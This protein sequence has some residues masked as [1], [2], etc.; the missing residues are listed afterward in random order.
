MNCQ[1]VEKQDILE[2]YL[3]GRLPDQDRDN[4]EQHYFEC[5]SCFAS[6]QIGIAAWEDLKK[7]P[8]VRRPVRRASFRQPW[9]WTPAFA[10]LLIVL[11]GIWWYAARIESRTVK[12]GT[13]SPPISQDSSQRNVTAAPG[14]EE[15][16][17][18]EPPPYTPIVVRGSEDS[19]H[20]GF[21]QAMQFYSKGDYA[22]AIPGLRSAARASP[23]VPSFS[24]YLGACYLLTG[25]V[26]PAIQFFRKTVSIAVPAYSEPSHFYLAKAYLKKRDVS[27][28]KEELRMTIAM[29]GGEASK[30]EGL[31]NQLGK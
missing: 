17:K 29:N 24:F 4:F 2:K 7:N 8:P 13:S 5:N 31:L 25:Q 26:D 27:A 6:V 1:E 9:I 14:I 22:R 16:A 10:A 15:L 28:A 3:L 20:E 18:V 23:D 12:V 21:R 11:G 30:A 19:A